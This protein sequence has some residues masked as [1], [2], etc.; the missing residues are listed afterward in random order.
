MQK[1][2]VL[3]YIVN[4]VHMLDLAG[5]LQAFY[6]AG[7]YDNPYEI[8]FVSDKKTATSSSHLQLSKFVSPSKIKLEKQD[9]V[10]IPGYTID[11]KKENTTLSTFLQK[12]NALGCTICS[13]CTGTFA[14][15]DSGILN[16]KS[17]TT[18]WKYTQLLQK[19]Y[20]LIQVE[21]NRL[22][23]K[24]QNIYSSAGI[25][26]GIDLA[27]FVL[28]EK[29][30]A[31]LAW[32]IAREL[33]VYIRRDGDEAQESIYLKYRSHIHSGIHQIQDHIIHHLHEKMSIDVLADKIFTSPR[34]LTRLF[35][36]ITGI[37]IGDYI[38]KMRIE[39]AKQL[40]KA[41][42]KMEAVAAECGFKSVTQ[43]RSLFKKK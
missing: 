4:D 7:N 23:V 35:K 39:R 28:E 37:T 11:N 36:K 41:K 32:K 40:I 10:I 17:C 30:G 25:A 1:N 8:F 34:N 5:A 13:I 21:E 24:D 43:L 6:E 27:L 18:H 9:I 19:K 31:E 3:F 42:Y 26:T 2:K 16:H 12:A 15:A 14:L 20:P 22:F 33:V 38:E 29:H